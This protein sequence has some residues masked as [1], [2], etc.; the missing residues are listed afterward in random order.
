MAESFFVVNKRGERAPV[1]F[2]K[3]LHRLDTLRNKKPVLEI[4]IVQIAQHTIKMMVNGI[5]TREL[6]NI[7]VQYCANSITNDSDYDKLAVRIEVDNLH[8]ETK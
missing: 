2:N 6:D 7:S 3:I 1:D 5:T 8:R 4:D